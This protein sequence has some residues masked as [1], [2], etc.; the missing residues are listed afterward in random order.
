MVSFSEQNEVP[1]SQ[2]VSST[3]VD[4]EVAS[5]HEVNTA[6]VDNVAEKSIGVDLVDTTKGGKQVVAENTMQEVELVATD[7]GLLML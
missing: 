5:R 3:T 4:T 1:R 6:V 7:E 2:E